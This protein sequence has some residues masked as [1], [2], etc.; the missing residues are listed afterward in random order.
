[1]WNKVFGSMKLI[2]EADSVK[3]TE[4]AKSEELTKAIENSRNSSD[5][6]HLK[7]LIAANDTITSNS[8]DDNA[9]LNALTGK[10]QIVNNGLNEQENK[11]PRS[12]A[13][14]SS[15]SQSPVQRMP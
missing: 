11:W 3:G 9:E 7:Y 14:S 13:A 12:C 10:N 5:N 6:V 2:K 15:A 1:M 8:S 4:R